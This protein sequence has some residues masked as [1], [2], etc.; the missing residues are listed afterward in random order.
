MLRAEVPMIEIL[1]LIKIKLVDIPRNTPR[2]I[3]GPHFFALFDR[4]LG[5]DS[6]KKENHNKGK[7]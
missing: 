5:L 4:S 1:N 7:P 2:I 3:S 6:R